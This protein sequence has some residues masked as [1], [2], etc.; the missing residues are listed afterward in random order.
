[1]AQDNIKNLYEALKNDYDLGSEQEFRNS[2]K[3]ANNRRNL[4]SAIENDYDLGSEQDFEKSL[5]YGNTGSAGSAERTESAGTFTQE[6]YGKLSPTAQEVAQ[7]VGVAPQTNNKP[8]KANGPDTP[9]MQFVPEAENVVMATPTAETLKKY[10]WLK[11]DEAVPFDRNTG[12]PL[13]TWVDE[14]GN[15]ISQRDL[16]VRRAKEE[17]TGEK[18]YMRKTPASLQL[19]GGTTRGVRLDGSISGYVDNMMKQQYGDDY[20]NKQYT[21]KDGRQISGTELLNETAQETYNELNEEL[22]AARIDMLLSD[23]EE[24]KKQLVDN[25]SKK[26]NGVISE[27]SLSEALNDKE[28]AREDLVAMA[29]DEIEKARADE[30]RIRAEMDRRGAELDS[31]TSP[32]ADQTFNVRG[33][34][35]EYRFLT[36]ELNAVQDRIKSWEAVRDS[37]DVGL[38]RGLANTAGNIRTWDLG[39]S[40]FNTGLALLTSR[41]EKRQELVNLLGGAQKAASLED[42]TTNN[43]YRW[44]KIAG[45]SLPFAATFMATGGGFANIGKAAGNRALRIAERRAIDGL[46]KNVVKN[47]GVGLGEVASSYL[48]ATTAQGLGTAGDIMRRRTGEIQQGSDGN[49]ELVNGSSWGEAVYKGA[50]AAA[51]ENYTEMLGAHINIGKNVMNFLPKIGMGRVSDWFLK[52]GKQN[53]YNTT[54]EWLS[55]M[56]VNGYGGEVLEEEIAIPLNAILVGDNPLLF[57]N[58]GLL[59][60]DTQ[61][62]ILGGMALSIAGMNAGTLAAYGT[63]RGVYAAMTANDERRLNNADATALEVLGN[64]WNDIKDDIDNTPNDAMPELMK[65]YA[66]DETM[67][68]EEKEAVGGYITSLLR[69]RGHNLGQNA[70]MQADEEERTVLNNN[71]TPEEQQNVHED[72]MIH[73]V[74]LYPTAENG[75]EPQEVFITK[76]NVVMRGDGTVD[77][78]ASSDAIYYKGSDGQVHMTSPDKIQSVNEPVSIEEYAAADAVNE[79]NMPNEPNTMEGFAVGDEVNVNIGGNNYTATVQ[80]TDGN[81]NVQVYYQNEDG[82]DVP[83]TFTIDE[84]RN[85]NRPNDEQPPMGGAGAIVEEP[86]VEIGNSAENILQNDGFSTGNSNISAENIPTEEESTESIESAGN[87]AEEIIPTD[88][89]GNPRYYDAPVEATIAD[90]YDGSLDDAEVQGF[91]DANINEAQKKYDNIQ[92]KAPK[93]GTNKAK[94]LEQKRKWQADVDEAKRVLDYWNEVNTQK[95]SIT[96]TT[97]QE[98]EA[99][100]AELSGQ[101]AREEYTAMR[102]NVPTNPVAVAS[103]FIRGAKITPESFRAETGYGAGE[104]RRF[105]GMIATEQNGGKSIDRLAEELV[106]YD[107]AEL[108]GVTFNGDTS[109][110][111]DAILEALQGAS[112][113]GELAVDNTA[114]QERYVEA[115]RAEL[116]A[117]YMEAYGMTY[118][119]YL[120]YEEQ[121]LPEMLRKYANFDEVEFYNLYADEIEQSLNARINEQ[122]NDTTGEEPRAGG[123]DEVL[124]G[125]RTDNAR[126]S[127]GGTEQ[128]TEVPAGVQGTVEDG[129]ISEETSIGNGQSTFIDVIRTLYT[130]GKEVASRLFS[131]KFFDVATTPKFMKDLGLRGDKFTIRYGVISRHFNKDNE[132]DLSEEIWEQLPTAIQN[133]FAI[134]RYFTD[135]NR[136]QQKGYRLYTTLQLGNGSYVVVSAEV[137]NA[138]RDLEVNAINTVFGRNVLSDVHDELIY[139]SETI[140]PEQQSLL[141]GNNPRQYPANRE[142]SESKDTQTSTNEQTIGEKFAQNEKEAEHEAE[143][144]SRVEVRDDDWQEGDNDKPTY[145][146]SIIIDGKHTA[147]QVDQPDKYGHYT[148]SYFEFDNKRFGNIAEIVDYIDNGHT[149]A[150]KIAQAEAET[151]TEPTE[152]QK[153]AGNYKKG[154]VKIDGFDVTIENPKG[155]VRSG[156][157]AD[158]TPWSV[159][160]NNT[161]GYIRGTEGVDGDHIDVY[162]SDNPT[163]GNVFV[164]DQVNSDGSFDE[165]KVMYGFNSAEEARDAYLANYSPGWQGLGTITE[166]TKDEFKKWVGSSHRKTK[167]FAEYKSVKKEGGQNKG[168]NIQSDA[169]DDAY[170]KT[171]A[172]LADALKGN[173]PNIK[174]IKSKIR[175]YKKRIKIL[176]EGAAIGVNSDEELHKV[177]NSVEKLRGEQKAYEDILQEI[178]ERM[179]ADESQTLSINDVK[180]VNDGDL[181]FTEPK[182]SATNEG[183]EYNPIW[184]Y[185]VSVDKQTGRTTLKRDDVSGPIPIGDARFT[186]NAD[187]PQEMLDI[188]RN[189]NNGMQDVLDAVGVTLENKANIRAIE[190][191][192]RKK[193]SSSKNS[194]QFGLVS[195]E[196]MEELKKRLKQKVLG[197]MNMGIDPEILTI[198]MELTAGYIDRGIKTFADYAKVMIDDLG[199][200]IRPYLKSF[201]NGARDLPEVQEAGL[202]EEMTPY[203]DVRTFDVANFDKENVNALETMQMAVQEREATRQADEAKER[204]TGKRSGR[205]TKRRSKKAVTLIADLFDPTRNKEE[206][207]KSADD[208]AESVTEVTGPT[209]LK[210]D[211]ELSGNSIDY[212]K[213][214]EE[215]KNFVGEIAGEISFKASQKQAGNEYT[216]LTMTSIKKLLQ[217]YDTLKDLST[218]DIQELV[219]L[220]MTQLSRLA[221]NDA[222]HSKNAGLQRA[223]YE[224]IVTLYEA[225]PTLNARDSSRVERQ[226]YSTPTPYGY[227]MGQFV[228][229]G[230]DVTSVLEPSA[231]NGALTIAFA[232]EIVHVNDID[233]R[234]LAN[235]RTLGY[236]QITGQNA[237]LPFEG[238]KVDAVLTNPPFGSTTQ[239]EFDGIFKISSL[240]GLMAINALD[241]MKDDGR[242]AIII[243]GNTEYREN[244]VMKPKDMQFFGYLYSHYNVVDVIN[245]DGDMYARNGTKYPVRIILI[246]GRKT[247]DFKRVIPPVRNKGRAEQ[248]KT[249]DELYKRV[250][251]DILQLQ[252]VEN[253]TAGSNGEAETTDRGSREKDGENNNRA[254]TGNRTEP[255]RTSEDGGSTQS[256]N[257][258]AQSSKQER[259][260]S[261]SEQGATARMDN[262]HGRNAG[263]IDNVPQQQSARRNEQ[264]SGNVDDEQGRNGGNDGRNTPAQ[265]ASNGGRLAVGLTDE[266]V[267]YPNRSQSATLMSVVPANQAQVLASS[268]EE[269]GDVD[270]FLV[271]QLG[272]SSKE[273]LF[274]YLAAE[275]IDSVALA[276]N[277]MNKGNGFIIGD[278]TG[279]GKGRQGAAIIRY[280]VRQGKKP[281]YFTQKPALFADNY[282]DLSDIGSGDLRPFIIASSKDGIIT[283]ANGNVVHKLPTKK[284]TERVFDYVLKNGTLPDEYDYAITTYSQI[285]NGTKEYEAKGNKIEE[286]NKSY[287]KTK[288]PAADV[289][290]QQR[291]NAIEALS[292]GNIMILDE[293]HTVGGQGGGAMFMQYLMPDV[294]GVT[295]LSATFAKRADNMPLYAMRTALSESGMK[296]NE[297]IEAILRGGVTL[298]EIMSKQLVQSGQMIRRERS[299]QGVTIDWMPVS[300]EADK[301]QR[302]Q[303]DEVANIFNDIRAFQDDYIKPL[304]TQMSEDLAEV[305]S[306]SDI[307][308]GTEAMGVKNTPFASKMYNLVNQLLFALKADAVADRVIWNLQHGFKPVVSF[309]NTM[310]GFLADAP[311]D[312]PMDKIP[313]FSLTLL[314]ALD[315]VMRYQV[316]NADNETSGSEFRL[317]DLSPE[318]R[319]KYNEIHDRIMNMS[320]NLPISPMDAIKMK[321]EDAGYSV[322]EITGRTTELTKDDD[323]KYIVRNRTDRDKKAAARDFNS[324]KIDVLMINKSGSTGISLHSSPKFADQ[325]QRVMVFAQF[326]QDINDEVQMRGRID[327]TGQ[328]YRGKYEYIVSSIPA[329]QRLQMMFKAK[330]KSLD[331][332]TTSSQKSKFNEMQVVDYLNKYGDEVTWQYMLE[333]PELSEKLGDPLK[334]LSG[335]GEDN[336]NNSRGGENI[337][338]QD[339]CAAKIARYLPFLP[340]KEQ[341]EVFKDITEAYQVKIQLLNDAGENDLEITTMPLRAQTKKRSIWRRG[342]APNSGN[343]FADNTYLEEVEVDVLKKPMKANEIKSMVSRMADGKDFETWRNEKRSQ[344]SDYYNKKINDLRYKLTEQADKRV[345]KQRERFI[346][347]AKKARESGKN[348]F[349]DAEIADQAQIAVESVRKDA[350]E[351][352]EKQIGA[353]EKRRNELIEV[354]D[355]FTPL[356]PLVIPLDLRED[357]VQTTFTPSYGTFVGY[358]FSKEFSPSTSTAIFATLDGRRKVELPLRS[359]RIFNGIRMQTAMN[360]YLLGDINMENWNSKVPTK[361]RRTAYIVTGNLLQALV[362]TEKDAR[363]KGYLISY[364]TIDGDTRQGILMPER[365]N[366]NDLRNSVPISS[367]LQQIRN[368]EKTESEDGKISVAITPGWRSGYILRVPKSTQAG[369]KYFTD[370][371]LR[372]LVDNNEFETRGNNMVANFGDEQLPQV[373]DRLDK[374]GVTVLQES[375]LEEVGND[376]ISVNEEEALLRSG[377]G[378]LTDDELANANDPTSRFLGRSTRTA[379]QRREFAERERGRMVDRVN[380]LAEKMHLDNVE[381][382][383]DASILQ[384]RR[385]NAKGFFSRSTGKITIV[386]PNN[387]SI[388]DVEQTL[389]HEAVA[390]YGLRRLFG[391]HFDTFIDN[392]YNNVSPELKQRIDAMSQEHGWSTRVAT[393]E[394]LASLAENTN[395]EDMDASW[396][397]KIKQFF[398]QMLHKIGF[399]DFSGVT[400]SDNE[401]RYLLWRSYENLAEPGRYRSI[402]GEVRDIS[403]QH[404]MKVGNYNTTDDVISNAADRANEPNESNTPRMDE[405]NRRFNDELDALNE[406]NADNVA[407]SLGRPSA[408][409]RAAGVEDKPMKLYG[410]KVIKK[411]KKHGFKLDE[412]HDLPKAVADPIAVFN[413]YQKDGNRSILTEMTIGDKNILVSITIGKGNDVDFNIVSSV[414]GKGKSNIIDWINKGYTAYIDKKRTLNYL[415]FSERSISEASSNRELLSAANIVKNFENPSFESENVDDDVLYREAEEAENDL[416]KNWREQYDRRTLSAA[417][418]FREAA[419]DGMRSVSILQDVISKETDSPI[420]E[421]ENVWGLQNRLSSTNKYEQD[422]YYENYYK[423]LMRE[424]GNLVKAGAKYDEL[425]RNM[426]EA[427]DDI[428]KYLI[429]K[430]GI[431]RNA[432][433]RNVAAAEARRPYEERIAEIRKSVE[434]GEITQEAADEQIDK[435]SEQANEAEEKS[436]IDTITR[437]YSGLSELY[438]DKIMFDTMAQEYVNNFES[439][440]DT[441]EL[442][443]KINA[444]TKATLRKTYESGLISRKQ[445]EATRDMYE[446]YI[447]LRGW[448][449]DVASEMYNYKGQQGVGGRIMK[450]AKGR[451]SLAENPLAV[452]GRMGQDGILQANKNKVKQRLYNLA[453][454][455][456][457]SLLSLKKQWYEN[458]GTDENPEWERVYP[459]LRADMSADEVSDAIEA[460]E[461]NMREL[462]E[463]GR[464]TQRREG[465]TLSYHTTSAQEQQHRVNVS[466]G[467]REYNIYVNGNPR[468]AQAINGEL[469]MDEGDSSI[470][471]R[472]NRWLANVYTSLNPEFVVTNYER[473]AGFAAAIVASTETPQYQADW[474]KNMARFNPLTTGVYI[475]SLINKAIKGRV[476]PDNTTERYMQEFLANGGETGFTNML[477]ADDYKKLINKE[478]KNVNTGIT[479][480]KAAR[481]FSGAVQRA[482]RVFEDATRFATY[483]TSREQGRSIDEAIRDAKEISLNFNTRGADGMRNDG[484]VYKFFRNLRHWV[485]FTNPSIQGLNKAGVAFR[486]HPVRSTIAIAGLPVLL[487]YGMAALA[488]ALLGD[489]DDEKVRESYMDLPKWVRRTNICIPIGGTK[490]VTIPLSYELRVSYGMGEMFWEIE[491]G[492]IEP[493]ELAKETLTQ[494]SDLLPLSFASGTVAQNVSPTIVRPLVDIIQ[495]KDFTGRPIWRENTFNQNMPEYTKAYAGTAKWFTKSAEVLNNTLPK[496]WIKDYPS[497]DKYT[498]GALDINPAIVEHLFDSY[499]GGLYTFPAKAAKTISM[500]WDEDM[501]DVRNIPFINRNLKD[502]RSGNPINRSAGDRYNTYMREYR[503]SK[504]RWNGYRRETNHGVTDFLD[505]LINFGNT[506]QGQRMF[507]IDGY[508]KSLDDI[509]KQIKD[510]GQYEGYGGDEERKRLKELSD[511]LKQEL[512]NKL[513]SVSIQN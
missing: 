329:E 36:A 499:L 455:H 120:A 319:A 506:P 103:D 410:N 337:K 331:A 141:N 59:D 489:D 352:M 467:G 117:Q 200:A 416:L 126:G 70:V 8:N 368:G 306:F 340:V 98:I 468:A 114:E 9:R 428:L 283:D 395:F 342:K 106:S 347:S 205:S 137:K 254:N 147:T 326:Q 313:N 475:N 13:H 248:V 393:E 118:E 26:W 191:E 288:I 437:D 502:S 431:E 253:T 381:I 170:N 206:K 145:K 451:K 383:T 311:K 238:E 91:I 107:N 186:L 482:N 433:F 213:R 483:V 440:F 387:T 300:E 89:D 157:D 194:G 249:F 380:E 389:L 358:K 448:S 185:S 202:S 250:Q 301:K 266:K 505:K 396:W 464:A 108:N 330:L 105:V 237:L 94:Y 44:A 163:E 432:H 472:V 276:I 22:R 179:A 80:G 201:Y 246:N 169:Y 218:T 401:L 86:V 484:I 189:P 461:E 320:A 485:I 318:G 293:S 459:E 199:D 287:K 175:N 491:Q 38:L 373:L 37:K 289:S 255:I 456:Q 93:I 333:H 281:I 400:L 321:I 402:I 378:T 295:F 140:T 435:L 27:Q 470:V 133:P 73:T 51:I 25:L 150:S 409:L 469:R 224:N 230:K 97:P 496:F 212:Q 195:D 131:M 226:Q 280:A 260:R 328:I 235:L 61:I 284:E 377:E 450:R 308:R 217:K 363:T 309:T 16:D 357:A 422:Y 53:W 129:A 149:L 399:E 282:R 222:V 488:S 54:K 366:P 436:R 152:A 390:H 316:T 426:S 286:K 479:A 247:G 39:M 174:N 460:F 498:P 504:Q 228:M 244:G 63:Q 317:S 156:K 192:E 160:M 264:R 180:A 125:E 252:Q 350:D 273:E 35:S 458:V 148:G 58:G 367:R 241:S 351:R 463:D 444:A 492:L 480:K 187:S 349:T 20:A 454:A 71:L 385:A 441:T 411:M 325:R 144:A 2:L 443:N 394:Y 438:E 304:V 15:P 290:G 69:S 207:A 513:D 110:A 243:G 507:I 305:G 263:S 477:T 335:K 262:E 220:A 348:T 452:I 197:Q 32:F 324:G 474:I 419:Q 412:L 362:D 449:N 500:V 447:P 46:A 211:E 190:E 123:G 155:S 6:E 354:L 138:G 124:P 269:I 127:A 297:M 215:E 388:F 113:R 52:A 90:L 56:G 239:K 510:M 382:V 62:D 406:E 323:G 429:S 486:N 134:T 303:F 493:S 143:L 100:Q 85:M 178:N 60:K 18:E 193:N 24:Q 162:L 142:L 146:R 312:T 78:E 398:L 346:K 369:A 83:A 109:T 423:P 111:K 292:K 7:G 66:A 173:I 11:A 234:R 503:L 171:Y 279:V 261:R 453:V 115:R 23:D 104:Q 314:R 182:T 48:L 371:E 74:L 359:E 77:T 302:E 227:V 270:Q 476:N 223:G 14:Q 268:L 203:D 245:M 341:E 128:G 112:T 425:G 40:D 465:L 153:E 240:E 434:D 355:M 417:F 365:F 343:A 294:S 68:K 372:N 41:G 471:Q 272:Y 418:K 495:N 72:G 405:E 379:R 219:E 487:G 64:K 375:S 79:P 135:E 184:Q 462:R 298:Q 315:G 414:F 473:D 43:I 466:I 236:G 274:S 310:E 82:I 132:H 19:P 42:Q 216:P 356:E 5:G 159:T 344:I 421:D 84:L 122:G 430:H 49:Y 136:K 501:R 307:K 75:G 29:G 95:E 168:E 392:V 420:K 439:K 494:I 231:G 345:E 181:I 99:A 188:L 445:Y 172:A 509:D 275:Q 198:G 497:P 334:M 76:G 21:T 101:N 427:E 10:P 490:F 415:H 233:E 165:H 1:M 96:H 33:V 121:K 257:N 50:T 17:I 81:G 167:P 116:D 45:E 407:L 370:N 208:I 336:T 242:A 338:P 374:L 139:T 87:D 232:P 28:T 481:V 55:R 251:D 271:D 204:I 424:V 3:D 339:D 386:I 299:F 102:E 161:Y 151:D 92:K 277:Q 210:S 332:N 164:I 265:P 225:Q 183:L 391:E 327:R 361:S 176:Q 397:G 259:A 256:R 322:G 12:E 30:R 442:W 166:V 196:R 478:I 512:V 508:K 413:N 221:A 214:A 119:D 296:P 47:M 4:Y 376:G 209:S 57:G 384:G 67:S 360:S 65:E 177:E 457:T 446:Y 511:S 267:A 408:I 154:H 285:Q 88:E 158:G 34:D 278:M 404:E 31:Q 364:S 229:A 353:I 403:K 258:T 130:R 291:R